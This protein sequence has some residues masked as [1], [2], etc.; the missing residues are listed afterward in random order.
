[1]PCKYYVLNPTTG[2]YVTEKGL[3]TPKRDGAASFETQEEAV[4][5]CKK[6]LLTKAFAIR[7][8]DAERD[9][10]FIENSELASFTETDK[11]HEP[12]EDE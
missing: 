4:D 6:H 7:K 8:Y 11:L 10:S 1:M 3:A 12:D 5:F 2:T 9:I